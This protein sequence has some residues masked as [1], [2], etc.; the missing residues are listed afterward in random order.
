MAKFHVVLSLGSIT[1]VAQQQFA[2]EGKVSF[3][4]AGMVTKIRVEF[5]KVIKFFTNLTENVCNR[6][7]LTTSHPGKKRISRFHI[8]FN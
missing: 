8:Q 4:Q 1:E 5:L 2:E 6:L 3:H 7:G